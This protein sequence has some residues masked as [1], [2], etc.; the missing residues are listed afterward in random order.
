MFVNPHISGQLVKDRQQDLLASAGRQRLIRQLRTARA[1]SPRSA[2]HGRRVRT[3][4]MSA[5]TRLRP[6]A[7]A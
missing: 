3:W 7:P 2:A 4:V 1:D 6:A 5:V